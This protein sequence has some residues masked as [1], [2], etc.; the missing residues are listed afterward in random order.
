MPETFLLPG[1]F[2]IKTLVS[3]ANRWNGLKILVASGITFMSFPAF[4]ALSYAVTGSFMTPAHVEAGWQKC[5]L[6]CFMA[7]PVKHFW[8]PTDTWPFMINFVVMS[9]SIV[10]IAGA[11]V[12]TNGMRRVSD[13]LFPY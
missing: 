10:F 11:F 3:P 5:S 8:S 2:F 4:L 1:V 13:K 7:S 12:M 9:L 6:V